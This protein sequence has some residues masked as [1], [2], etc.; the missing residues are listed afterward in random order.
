MLISQGSAIDLYK[1]LKNIINGIQTG[2]IKV[3]TDQDETWENV[4]LGAKWAL[5]N[6]EREQP[7]KPTNTII[8]T[9]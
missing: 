3:E 1:A 2:A 8:A 9:K 7:K 6:A 5:A 4:F